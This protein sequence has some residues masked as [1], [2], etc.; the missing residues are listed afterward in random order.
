MA[1]RVA[2]GLLGVAAVILAG[3]GSTEEDARC[4]AIVAKV[5]QCV[6]GDPGERCSHTML[7]QYDRIMGMACA[8]L[9]GG[10][11]DWLSYGGCDDNEV[12]CG[13]SDWFCCDLPEGDEY[14]TDQPPPDDN[15]PGNE[16]KTLAQQHNCLACHAVEKKLVGPSMKQIA[17]TYRDLESAAATL[18][19]KVIEGGYG[20]FGFIPMP[21]YPAISDED[22]DVIL[23]WIL[24][25]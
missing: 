4:S 25:L 1:L 12:P 14:H 19:E 10:K 16:A 3:C 5:A 17:E 20:T 6:G 22:L 8:D 23:S 13:Y 2:L 18:K 11:A 15:Q 9:A 24:G 7:D 21:P